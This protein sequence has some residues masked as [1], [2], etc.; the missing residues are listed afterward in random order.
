MTLVHIKHIVVRTEYWVLFL[1]K[2]T[3][4][5]VWFGTFIYYTGKES[6][7]FATFC[8]NF[9]PVCG[10]VGILS[11][12]SVDTEKYKLHAW[13]ILIGIIFTNLILWNLW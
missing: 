8:F 4:C 11:G 5:L 9:W 3:F 13:I 12:F 6:P 1:A 2:V 10:V 7:I